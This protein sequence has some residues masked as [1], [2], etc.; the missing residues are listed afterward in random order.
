[1]KGFL[2]AQEFTL[3]NTR[4]VVFE[5][6]RGN[7]NYNK[8]DRPRR[9][10]D[11]FKLRSDIVKKV[12]VTKITQREKEFVLRMGYTISDSFVKN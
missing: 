6:M 9:E 1:M 7:V 11:V 5:L 10:T 8:K 2:D 3:M 4:K 12:T